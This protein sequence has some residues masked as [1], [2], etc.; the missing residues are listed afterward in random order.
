VCVQP[1][2]IGVIRP[3]GPRT[4]LEWTAQTKAFNRGVP[5]ESYK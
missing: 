3:R 2:G 5:R 1:R 4:H